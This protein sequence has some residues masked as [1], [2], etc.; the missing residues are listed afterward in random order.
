MR[1][2]TGAVNEEPMTFLKGLPLAR[3]CL[4]LIAAALLYGGFSWRFGTPS[5][6]RVL[7][8]VR[9]LSLGLVAVYAGMCLASMGSLF[10]DPDEANILAISSASLH[11]QPVY[12][13]V[14]SPDFSYVIMYGPVTFLLYR[15]VL[16][17]VDGQIVWIR[18]LMVLANL[19][20]MAAL[21]RLARKAGTTV[22]GVLLA[23]ALSLFVQ[24]TRVML[25]ARPDIWL[26]LCL[27]LAVLAAYQQRRTWGWTVFAGVMLGL[28]LDLKLTAAILVAFVLWLLA[29]RYGS[30]KATAAACVTAGVAGLPFFMSC[31]SLRNYRDLLRITTTEGIAGTTM[32]WNALMG[33]FL[34]VGVLMCQWVLQRRGVKAVAARVWAP[35]AGIML[36]AC[37]AVCVTAAKP[38]AGLWYFF[39]LTPILLGYVVLFRV[40]DEVSTSEAGGHVGTLAAG[41][42][43]CAYGLVF[44]MYVPRAWV[45]LSVASAEERAEMQEAR[46]ELLGVVRANGGR[47]MQMAYGEEK[48]S[49]FELLRYLL[50]LRG[51]PYALDG[52]MRTTAY[53]VPFPVNIVARM[54]RCTNDVWVIPRG[55]TPFANVFFPRDLRETFDRRYVLSGTG[56]SYDVWACRRGAAAVIPVQ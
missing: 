11:G 7:W 18:L 12:H 6:Q 30:A 40:E 28:A 14:F 52:S 53:L 17:A 3:F 37:A 9:V 15:W 39:P 43:A 24:Q 8:L 42:L 1:P 10:L 23:L 44:L 34:L 35:G 31:I 2:G 45:G 38:G 19:G 33:V 21:W 5:K 25:G 29:V 48:N 54:D 56:R 51:E 16:V 41:A 20:L 49:R 47:T 46:A 32:V 22:A 55:Q 27:T 13:D 36:V 26:V 4:G 50:P